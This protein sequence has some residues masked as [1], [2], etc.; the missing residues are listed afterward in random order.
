MFKLVIT[1]TVLLQSLLLTECLYSGDRCIVSEGQGLCLP[2][3][4]CTPIV[5]EIKAAGSP[6][7]LFIRKKLQELTCGFESHEPMVCCL[8]SSQSLGTDPG[9][10]NRGG[11]PEDPN[12]VTDDVLEPYTRATDVTGPVSVENHPNLGLLPIQCGNIESDRIWGGNRTRLYEMPWMVLLSYN[13]GRGT[14]LSCGGSLINEWYVLTAAH[15]VSFLGSRLKLDGV[16]LGEYDVR[17]DP[18]CEMSDGRKYCA[19]KVTNMTIDSVVAHPGYTP[20]TLVDDI[21]LIR[22]KEPADFTLNSMKPLCLPITRDLQREPLPGLNGV[23]AGWGVTED[24]LQSPILLSVELPIITQKECHDA[25]RGTPR[26][27][28]TQLCAGG[29]KDKD[30]CGGDSGGPLMYP[31]RLGTYGVRYVQRGIVSY[32]PKRCGIGGFP[33]V[34]T[35][36]AYY[37]DWILDNMHS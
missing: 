21:A 12:A 14:K 35:N 5:R 9:D 34:Y 1:V 7:P 2:L 30:S 37:M 11:K 19:P 32:G 27:R 18:D 31:G 8:S 25:Y 6:M 29:V 13:S 16:I 4:D 33:G 24:G 26:V 22:L 17:Q 3:L 20:Q 28:E 23:V 36:V 15:C 10:P